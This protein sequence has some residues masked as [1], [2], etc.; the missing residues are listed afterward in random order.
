MSATTGWPAALEDPAFVDAVRAGV[1]EA[2]LR[3]ALEEH[4]AQDGLGFDAD[5]WCIRAEEFLALS[6]AAEGTLSQ[7][8]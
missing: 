7:E 2:L 4:L 3:E 1:S 5:C 8:V 6:R